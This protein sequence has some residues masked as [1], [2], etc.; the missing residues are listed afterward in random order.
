MEAE[1]KF[2]PGSAPRRWVRLE[3]L[4]FGSTLTGMAVA[5][6]AMTLS[7]AAPVLGQVVHLAAWLESLASAAAIAGPIASAAVGLTL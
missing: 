5:A 3:D 4:G 7:A 6:F 2:W 1:R